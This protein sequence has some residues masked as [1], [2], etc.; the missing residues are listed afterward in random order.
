MDK[1]AIQQ[2][3][4]IRS[5]LNSPRDIVLVTHRNPDGDALGSMLGMQIYLQRCGHFVKSIAP[6][7]FPAS[8]KW[9]PFSDQIIIH[10]LDPLVSEQAI[11]WASVV[12]CLDFNALDRIDKVGKLISDND[13]ECWLVDHHVDPEPFA[14]IEYS[15]SS[16]SS[17]C[18]MVFEIIHGL[19][20][21]IK[22][23]VDGGTCLFTGILTDTGSFKHSTSSR[24]FKVVSKLKE[25]GVDDYDIQDR[26]FNSYSEKR[27][28]LLGHCLAN[29]M[30]LLPEL[31]SGII[32]LT[33]ADYDEF[34][35]S[36]GDTEG[37]VNY[38]LMMPNI[39]VAAFITEQPTL[40]K[41]SLRSKGNISV[42]ALAR[43]HFNGGGHINASGGYTFSSLGQVISKFK[44]V[45]KHYIPQHE[46]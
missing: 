15:N 44:R 38:L 33:K 26:V 24:L 18:E 43:E 32:H 13:K 19:D 37:I 12:I 39:K 1:V 31:K 28:R 16:A 34:D 22:L 30:E 7:E 40:V 11:K 10:D 6:S 5:E 17:T 20:D 4:E 41:L 27:L 23:G 36:R 9:M 42:Q 46:L 25:M 14:K 45:I 3:D 29:R 2:L 21:L 8:F 35:I